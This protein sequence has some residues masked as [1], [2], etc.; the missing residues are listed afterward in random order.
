MKK[1]KKKKKKVSLTERNPFYRF[2]KGSVNYIQRIHY[3]D[4][5]FLTYTI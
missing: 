2:I 5:A 1:K 4:C 3:S